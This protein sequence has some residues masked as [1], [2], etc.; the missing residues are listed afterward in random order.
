LTLPKTWSLNQI[1]VF[2]NAVNTKILNEANRRWKAEMDKRGMEMKPG[3]NF[4]SFQRHSD[5]QD[6]IKAQMGERFYVEPML[7]TWNNKAFYN[8]VIMV[9]INR[10]RDYWLNYM[11]SA[12]SQFEDG[13]PM[14]EDGKNA[15][16][17][18]IVPPIS[19]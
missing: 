2:K 3:L 6:Q 13:A 1:T 9:N 4:A 14:A 10:E 12:V 17:S 7:T 8:N 11:E 18:I 5:I 15:L 16:R 19:M